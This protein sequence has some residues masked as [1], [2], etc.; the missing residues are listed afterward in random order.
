[1]KIGGISTRAT[2]IAGRPRLLVKVTAESGL[3]G[4]GESGLTGREHAVASVVDSI[5]GQIV[6]R[7][8]HDTEWIRRIALDQVYME[9]GRVAVAALGAIDVALHDLR[10]K[11]L[12]VPTYM[13]IG[14]RYRACVPLF[15][16]IDITE[17]QATLDE[18]V[19]CADE[20]WPAFRLMVC[21]PHDADGMLYEPRREVVRIARLCNEIRAAVGSEPVLGIDL[22]HR[23][24]V[25]DVERLLDLLDS[26]ALDFLEEPIRT[27]SPRAYL[28]LRR[29]GGP[30][31]AIGEEL[32]STREFA[33][34]LAVGALDFA[35]ID[36]PLLGGF[37]PARRVAAACEVEHVPVMPHNPFSPL[38]FAAAAH[39]ALATP[40]FS[41]L[42]LQRQNDQSA[43]LDA[44]FTMRPEV[45]SGNAFV[46]DATGL[47]IEIDE[48][49][50]PPAEAW[51]APVLMGDDGALVPW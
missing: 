22:H 29:P 15:Q 50:L 9:G 26:G 5:A 43:E 18:A 25:P 19:R 35:R 16:S 21:T 51:R 1:M 48:N 2:V 40:N 46:S 20:G 42:E 47:G 39:F 4:W 7:S 37:G 14:G 17:P 11:V 24:T 8:I 23:F 6:G 27:G 41:F 36:I 31:L 28:K 10:G 33:D 38:G 44:I 34:L 30:R 49:Q 12:D 3:F 13:L 45:S 32:T